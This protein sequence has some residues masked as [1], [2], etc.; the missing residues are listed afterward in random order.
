[1]G[2]VEELVSSLY[3]KPDLG[4]TSCDFVKEIGPDKLIFNYRNGTKLTRVEIPGRTAYLKLSISDGESGEFLQAIYNH[5]GSLT[6]A[7]LFF[8]RYCEQSNF[9]EQVDPPENVLKA[10]SEMKE[11]AEDLVLAVDFLNKEI[12]ISHIAELPGGH[13]KVIQE[14]DT[15]MDPSGDQLLHLKPQEEAPFTPIDFAV[16][17]HDSI[18]HLGF[19]VKGRRAVIDSIST[20]AVAKDLDLLTTPEQLRI[21]LEKVNVRERGK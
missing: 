19:R 7:R 3:L 13:L 11:R 1:M 14:F 15:E 8:K 5:D 6:A 4:G 10:Y 9:N 18:L 16:F 2:R 12:V 21:F 20:F 17:L